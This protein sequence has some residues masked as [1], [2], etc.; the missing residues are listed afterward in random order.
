MFLLGVDGLDPLKKLPRHLPRTILSRIHCVAFS[1]PFF[2][3]DFAMIPTTAAIRA[4]CQGY[5][6]SGR[7][8]KSTN[9]SYHMRCIP[10]EWGSMDNIFRKHSRCTLILASRAFPCEKVA[11]TNTARFSYNEIYASDCEKRSASTGRYSFGCETR[12]P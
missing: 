9:L 8:Q 1:F 12:T 7:G 6:Q 3:R 2:L 5:S 11:Q 10:E 4:T